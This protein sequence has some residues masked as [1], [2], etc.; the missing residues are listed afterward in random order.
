M[1]KMFVLDLDGTLLN[2]ESQLPVK[3]IETIK[4]LKTQ[5]YHFVIATGRPYNNCINFYHELSLDTPIIVDNGAHIRHPKNP[6]F[7]NITRGVPAHMLQEIFYHTS[8]YTKSA[9]FMHEDDIYSFNH[10][11]QLLKIFLIKEKDIENVVHCQLENVEV[12]PCGLIYLIDAQKQNEFER[13]IKMQFKGELTLRHWGSDSK[14]AIYEIYQTGVSKASAIELVAKYLNVEASEIMVFGDGI[15]DF[16]MIE[17]YYGVAM[18][19]GV[20]GL[21]LLA[22]DITEKTND[23]AG[24]AYHLIKVL[25]S[26][27]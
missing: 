4:A 11:P 18:K 27:F 25:K 24:V 16:E 22:K 10:N 9:F 15:N 8:A 20:S 6:N 12:D 13:F 21:K 7:K 19:N 17:N 26:D 14:N 1:F 5:G 3:N 23:E 2:D